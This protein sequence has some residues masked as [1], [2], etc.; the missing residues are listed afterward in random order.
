MQVDLKSTVYY[1][2]SIFGL[3]NSK[4]SIIWSSEYKDN[5]LLFAKNCNMRKNSSV[6]I[7][8]YSKM[9]FRFNVV[10]VTTMNEKI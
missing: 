4:T 7:F 6:S 1:I 3:L 9:W 10:K 5:I 8:S 2:N